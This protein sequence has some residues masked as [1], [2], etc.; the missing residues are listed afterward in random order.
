MNTHRPSWTRCT[1]EL[2][3]VFRLLRDSA[4]AFERTCFEFRPPA[5]PST[6]QRKNIL[7]TLGRCQISSN[8]T[9]IFLKSCQELSPDNF[10]DNWTCNLILCVWKIYGNTLIFFPRNWYFS[11]QSLAKLKFS[12]GVF[13]GTAAFPFLFRPSAGF[14]TAFPSFTA[15]QATHS[16]LFHRVTP[17]CEVLCVNKRGWTGE[18]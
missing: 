17:L 14:P 12:H 18:G 3:S 13:L 1:N 8:K 10:S 4:R 7:R 11:A 9:R 2:R 5:F 15:A 16:K 6:S